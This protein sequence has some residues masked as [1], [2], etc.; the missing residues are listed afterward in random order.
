MNKEIEKNLDGI[1]EYLKSKKEY[2][3]CIDLKKKMKN[4]KELTKLIE[5]IKKKQK[6]Y[7]QSGYDEKKNEE[8]DTL[9]KELDKY[10]IYL[11]YNNNLKVINE[12]IELLKEKLNDY[13]TGVME[14]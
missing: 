8:L 10:P 3:K 14:I 9:N 12:D 5:D 11:E 4:N 7:I 6:E 1:I 13:F 2:Q